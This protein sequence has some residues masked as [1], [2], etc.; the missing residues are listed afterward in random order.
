MLAL[1]ASGAGVF[2]SFDAEKLDR[3]SAVRRAVI[4]ALAGSA[5]AGAAFGAAAFARRRQKMAAGAFGLATL[6][7]IAAMIAA[8]GAALG[9]ASAPPA[10]EPPVTSASRGDGESSGRPTEVEQ[11][12]AVI[13]QRTGRVFFDRSGDG[14]LDSELV[15]CPIGD[16]GPPESL[17]PPPGDLDVGDEQI[18]AI[19][20]D[21]D[22]T[23]ERYVRA[24][25]INDVNVPGLTPPVNGDE[26]PEGTAISQPEQDDNE[27]LDD[28][29]RDDKSDIAPWLG[30]LF[31]VMLFVLLAAA[32]AAAVRGIVR[33]RQARRAAP[34]IAAPPEF[35]PTESDIDGEAAA[36]SF[37][38]SAQRLRDH[39]DPR[40]AIILAYA[41]LLD[42]LAQAG[43]ARRM[44][45]APE[46][47]LRRAMGELRVPPQPLEAVTQLFL[48]ARFSTHPLAEADR[49][50]ARAALGDAE[51]QLRVL[52]PAAE[53]T[54]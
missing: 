25:V 36:D 26:P 31:K 14:R 47:H 30:T 3:A 43:C 40:Q 27:N 29:N 24:E 32:L 21:C 37:A 18:I 9:A 1:A 42:G 23:V 35:P 22:G 52:A 49:D 46:E 34:P 51:A 20:D 16:T 28:K 4:G 39:P 53:A 10:T 11:G 8:L 45:E 44:H 5:L 13:D 12:G 15:A 19:D 33:A 41:S 2:R 7:A 48:L 38:A 17:A 50:T 54:T 6:A